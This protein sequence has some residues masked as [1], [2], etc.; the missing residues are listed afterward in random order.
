MGRVYRRKLSEWMILW[1]RSEQILGLSILWRV[2]VEDVKSLGYIGF[3][4]SDIERWEELA[5][6][7]LGLQLARR[8]ADGSL[9]LRLDEHGQRVVV[10][11]DASDDL[12]HA[13]W[14][15]DTEDQLEQFVRERVAMGLQLVDAGTEIAQR[16]GV[17][18]VY[19]CSDS[20]GVR[21]EFAFGPQY[22]P[23]GHPFRSS[24]LKSRFVAGPLGLGHF[25]QVSRDYAKTVEFCRKALGLRL[26]DYIRGPLETP[27]GPVP[28]DVTFLH[29]A[30][31]RHHSLATAQMPTPKH[32]HHVMFEVADMD[33]VGLARDRCVAAGFPIAMD[34]GHHPNDGMFSFYVVSP[35]GFLIEF[36]SGGAVIDDAHWEVKSYSQL[37]DWG[38]RGRA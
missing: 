14:L 23:S 9:V 7:V 29:S 25:V 8:E 19:G 1:C 15:F 5:V 26:S 20:D 31:G 11:P 27:R 21:H 12:M 3:G 22:A 36:G 24:V 2:A 13:G 33:D 35:S 34:L 17:E 37:S 32:I 16:R 38:H 18:R 28:L 10:S 4:V 30:T 6:D